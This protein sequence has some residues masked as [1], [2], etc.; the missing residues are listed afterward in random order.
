MRS[1]VAGGLPLLL[2]FAAGCAGSRPAPGPAVA[3]AP[4]PETVSLFGKPLFAPTLAADRKAELESRLSEAL[5][6]REKTRGDA[7]AIIWVGR[8]TAY[9]G[10]FREAVGIYTEGIAKYPRDARFYRHRGHRYITLR[11]FELAEADLARAASLVEGHADSVEPDGQPNARNVP[12]S[13]LHSNIWY[14]LGLARYLRGDF[15]GALA[16][17]RRGIAVS[18]NPDNLVSMSHW[19]YM[20]LRRLGRDGEA[21]AVLAPIGDGLDVIEN[22]DYYKLLRMYQG[23]LDAGTLWREAE[24]A[25]TVGSATLGYGVGNWHLYNGRREEAI[26]VFRQVERGAQWPAFGHIAAEADL[27]RLGATMDSQP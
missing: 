2:L 24:A 17:Y 8:R 26:P 7:D 21:A 14:H 5:A 10:R 19:L 3:S 9:L 12:T 4:E 25:E 11:R 20:T 15:D 16:A 22:G 13:T 27:K 6:Q 23:K 18:A 1:R